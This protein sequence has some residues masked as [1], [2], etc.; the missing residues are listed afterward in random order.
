MDTVN[1]KISFLLDN[2]LLVFV[3][4]YRIK[5][6]SLLLVIGILSGLIFIP[7]RADESEDLWLDIVNMR[8]E[9]YTLTNRL[10][11]VKRYQGELSSRLQEL[12]GQLSVT[13]QE[14]AQVQARIDNLE[15]EIGLLE[16][17][18]EQRQESL[19]S[20]E[21]I[22]DQAVRRLYKTPAGDWWQIVL[23]RGDLAQQLTYQKAF[24]DKVYRTIANISEEIYQYER[25]KDALEK[26]AASLISQKDALASVRN[27]IFSQASQV[28]A[29]LESALAQASALGSRLGSL[30]EE[31]NKAMVRHQ[32]LVYQSKG[33]CSGRAPTPNPQGAPSWRFYG[34]GTEHG[35]GMSQYGAYGM[36]NAGR[37]SHDI[38]T[39]YYSGTS[40]ET[41]SSPGRIKVNKDGVVLD[42]AFE[43][44]YLAG[45]GE[46]PNNW[47]GEALK[48]QIIAA[49]TYAWTYA[50][51]YP[52]AVICAT[53]SCQVYV[54]GQGKRAYAD[55][56]RGQVVVYGG[57]LAKTYYFST[58]GGHTDN[59][60]DSPSFTFDKASRTFPQSLRD[61][62]NSSFPYLRR[63][64][65]AAYDSSSP[66]HSWSGNLTCGDNQNNPPSAGYTGGTPISQPDMTL[67]MNAALLKLAERGG[68]L[69]QLTHNT[70]AETIISWLESEGTVPIQDVTEVGL[71]KM[72]GTSDRVQW[73][74]AVGS[75]R[76]IGA[77]EITGTR[78]RY[79]Y[80][81]LSPEKDWLYSTWFEV[82]KIS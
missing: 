74:T 15:E 64:D 70:P 50:Q 54:G 26:I 12:Q 72:G 60:G 68:H 39:Y 58:S 71:E 30:S 17:E 7:A 46:M 6:A 79:V 5:L 10:E 77:G 22:R 25:D 56:T 20:Q 51:G 73:V 13:D 37:S 55:A 33:T 76:S 67:I 63:V 65:D 52:G 80:N 1:S 35:I 69:D 2:R 66:F 3:M 27:Q 23:L 4:S 18:L 48:A 44:E 34:Y 14:I 61:S 49:R 38:L 78:F 47:P 28:E 82:E 24:I 59:V 45:I 75:N 29:Q 57:N 32:Q 16:D 11:E 42:L 62:K 31:I 81:L 53:E 19:N 8:G 36:A 41:W 9:Q 40:V 21:L 43:E